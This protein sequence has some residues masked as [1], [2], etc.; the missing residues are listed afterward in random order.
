M[1]AIIKGVV[2]SFVTEVQSTPLD[3]KRSNGPE[4]KIKYKFDHLGSGTYFHR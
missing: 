4:A 3:S 2:P 1:A